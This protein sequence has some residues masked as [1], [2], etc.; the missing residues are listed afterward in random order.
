MAV[1]H[2]DRQ[3]R[4]G[5]FYVH[6]MRRRGAIAGDGGGVEAGLPERTG[7]TARLIG[8]DVH[9]PD[10]FVVSQCH[11]RAR[12]RLA[13]QRDVQCSFR[14]RNGEVERTARGAEV[15][16]R[17]ETLQRSRAAGEDDVEPF[18]QVG[19]RRRG[20]AGG[21]RFLHRPH[22]QFPFDARRDRDVDGSGEPVAA[23]LHFQRG[24]GRGRRE[25]QD[26]RENGRRAHGH[27]LERGGD[28]SR[29]SR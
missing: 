18:R 19:E 3:R 11:S 4:L 12:K 25:Q 14:F 28:L 27:D 26:E 8:L 9:P 20:L 21:D 16:F 5:Q 17:A 10:Q 15:E 23:H 29:H 13:G 7:V 22:G 2:V 6:E 1:G 24:G